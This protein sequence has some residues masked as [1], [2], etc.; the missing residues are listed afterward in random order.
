M[1]SFSG[2]A[3]P[4]VTL[5]EEETEK[6]DA[7][8]EDEQCRI[9]LALDCEDWRPLVQPCAC[10]GSAGWVHEHCLEKWRRTGA[11]KD[12]AYRCGQCMDKYRD[13]GVLNFQGC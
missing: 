10:R 2:A 3:A 7:K 11:R 6:E 13:A 1:S 5:G 12:A 8:N 9:C 4:K